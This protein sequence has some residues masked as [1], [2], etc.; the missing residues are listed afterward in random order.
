MMIR[1][2]VASDESNYIYSYTVLFCIVIFLLFVHCFV[3]IQLFAYLGTQKKKSC[4]NTQCNSWP[5]P[6]LQI[7]L[8]KLLYTAKNISKEHT[9]QLLLI[10]FIYQ[11]TKCNHLYILFCFDQNVRKT[12]AVFVRSEESYKNKTKQKNTHTKNVYWKIDLI[13][14]ISSS[15]NFTVRLNLRKMR[16]KCREG[17]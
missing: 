10:T 12:L 6:S 15:K 14:I 7:N 1:N 4:K 16:Y 17:E 8:S 13:K 11:T 3:D 5:P 9:S 2:I